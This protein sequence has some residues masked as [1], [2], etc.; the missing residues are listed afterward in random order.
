MVLL[1][2][3]TH[4][5]AAYNAERANSPELIKLRDRVHVV[6]SDKLSGGI[7]IAN[8][9][10]NDGRKLSVTND[11]YKPLRNLAKQREVVSQKFM[12]LVSPALGRDR[13]DK[14]L[15]QILDIDTLPSVR[16]LIPL[17]LKQG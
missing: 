3:D 14:L 16:Q 7:A 8:V 1:G 13:A 15:R 2:D 12:R 11:C 5:I 4:D 17:T 9:Q 6:G 10:L